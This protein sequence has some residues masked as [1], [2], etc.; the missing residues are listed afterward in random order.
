EFGSH[1]RQAFSIPQAGAVFGRNR[2]QRAKDITSDRYGLMYHYF[3]RCSSLTSAAVL[4]VENDLLAAA[5]FASYV[6]HPSCAVDGAVNLVASCQE[7]SS[8]TH[9]VN[10]GDSSNESGP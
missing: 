6:G 9:S 10:I 4:L 7:T 8:G 1:Y 3:V 2:N 5:I